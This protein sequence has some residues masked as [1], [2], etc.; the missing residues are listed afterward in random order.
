MVGFWSSEITKH[1]V[2][3][4][5]SRWFSSEVGQYLKWTLAQPVASS[6]LSSSRTTEMYFFFIF[7]LPALFLLIL[8]CSA[9][10]VCI[11]PTT[12]T[13]SPRPNLWTELV[14]FLQK[15]RVFKG[16][17]HIVNVVYIFTKNRAILSNNA[18]FTYFWKH[19]K[20]NSLV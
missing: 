4:R 5:G 17:L 9:T 12:T 10:M 20:F 3:H 16:S 7:F 6:K 18:L 2:G 8:V 11:C 13:T 14:V 15:K 19:W 1:S